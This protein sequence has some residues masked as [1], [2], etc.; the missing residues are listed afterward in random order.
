MQPY[1]LYCTSNDIQVGLNCC[2]TIARNY[3]AFEVELRR[4]GEFNPGF[5]VVAVLIPSGKRSEYFGDVRILC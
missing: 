5:E 4:L 2:Q 3:D 1:I